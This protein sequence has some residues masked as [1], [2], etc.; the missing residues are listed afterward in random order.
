MRVKWVNLIL[1][2]LGNW[3]IYVTSLFVL[4]RLM[5]VSAG[6]LK[7]FTFGFFPASIP[8][9]FFQLAYVLSGLIN[10]YFFPGFFLLLGIKKKGEISFAN[11]LNSILL[12]ILLLI[13]NVNLARILGAGSMR[14]GLLSITS[15][16]TV[17]LFAFAC[18]CAVRYKK[19]FFLPA[20][21]KISL[22]RFSI[23]FVVL[24]VLTAM[25]ALPLLKHTN[26]VFN[27]QEKAILS[28]PIGAQTDLHEKVGMMRSLKNGF[29][30]FWHLEHARRFGHLTYELIP[31]YIYFINSVIFGDS[32]FIFY[33]FFFCCLLLAVSIAWE[34]AQSSTSE[35]AD[36]ARGVTILLAMCGYFWLTLKY[37]Y[38]IAISTHLWIFLLLLQIFILSIRRFSLF[39]LV[40]ILSFFTKEISLVFSWVLVV[41][42]AKMFL[43][44]VE[45]SRLYK[46]L[47]MVTALLLLFI[48]CFG[49][50]TKSLNILGKILVWDYL[51][52]YDYLGAF[53]GIFGKADVPLKPTMGFKNSIDFF[54]W[55]IGISFFQAMFFFV[56]SK[57]RFTRRLSYLGLA[58]IFAVL[59]GQFKLMH[60]ALF[61]ILLSAP[62][63]YR[64]LK[65]IRLGWVLI[66]ALL[67]PLFMFSIRHSY[68]RLFFEY[69]AYMNKIVFNNSFDFQRELEKRN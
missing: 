32:F 19:K 56:P 41:I 9:T 65:N 58:Y 23:V 10:F 64:K 14:W 62:V 17:A 48:F 6:T 66:M 18:Y 28:L 38:H 11:L 47:G 60:Y 51:L 53:Q 46:R 69:Y 43:D 31:T 20:Y 34:L 36:Y 40:C 27:C 25:F 42:F 4:A 33:V 44:R 49:F 22:K 52:R 24:L 57:D 61:P 21:L 16:V 29:F 45:A 13:L 2:W 68:N 55:I 63:C 37:P 3:V 8:V 30:P 50:F 26:F 7:V 5:N 15:A 67:L 35:A 59:I 12:S 54:A 1:S 39:Y